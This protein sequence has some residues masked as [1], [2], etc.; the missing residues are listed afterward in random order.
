MAIPEVGLDDQVDL[1]VEET[2]EVRVETVVDAD[3]DRVGLRKERDEEIGVVEVGA[4][5]SG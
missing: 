2:V 4:A 1:P 3:V 5:L